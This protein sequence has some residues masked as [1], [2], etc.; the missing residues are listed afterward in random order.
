MVD[1]RTKKV[2]VVGAGSSGVVAVKVLA[3]AG[4][5]VTCFEAGSGIGGNWRYENDNGMSAAY[6]SLHIN[7]SKTQMAY[8]DY[9][10]PESYPDYPGHEAILAYFEDYVDHFGIRDRIQ[11]ETTV[12]RIAPGARD[13]WDVTV[14]PRGGGRETHRFD[15]VLVAN[16]HHWKERWPDFPGELSPRVEVIHAHRYRTPSFLERKNVLVVGIGNSAVDIAC[17]ACRVARRT[18]LS[19]RRGRTSSRSTSSVGRPTSSSIRA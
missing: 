17:E 9:P 11:F 12:A 16:G 8:A 6:A 13:G 3:R 4:L 2:C 18:M 14:E 10:M 19:S 7:T 1:H 15:A 5:D